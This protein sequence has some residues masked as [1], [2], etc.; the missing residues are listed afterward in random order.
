MISVEKDE[1]DDGKSEKG[2]SREKR[3]AEKGND[4]D[5]KRKMKIFYLQRR[6]INAVNSQVGEKLP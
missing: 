6:K 1:R 2:K 5:S 4:G 3:V